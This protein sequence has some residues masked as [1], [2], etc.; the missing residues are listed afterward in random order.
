MFEGGYNRYNN[1]SPQ[2]IKYAFDSILGGF[3]KKKVLTKVCTCMFGWKPNFC[4]FWNPSLRNIPTT[5]HR[6]VQTSLKV[7]FDH[8]LSP[9]DQNMCHRQFT[10][11]A[12]LYTTKMSQLMSLATFCTVLY[13]RVCVKW[14][15]WGIQIVI[16][17][18][19]ECII[20]PNVIYWFVFIN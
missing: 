15:D 5:W 18:I 6:T 16:C 4:F 13:S 14:V 2:Y 17:K 20:L 11:C 12:V 8:S 19:A 7:P 3:S 9:I 10:I 1:Y